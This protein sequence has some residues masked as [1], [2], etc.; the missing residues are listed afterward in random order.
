M[1]DKELQSIHQSLQRSFQAKDYQTAN[2]LL[3]TA[4]IALIQR[5]VLLPTSSTPKAVLPVVRDILE[6]GALVSIY[7]NEEAAFS[8][9]YS[10]L[11]PFYD[12]ATI[13]QSPNKSKLIGLYLLLLLSKNDIAEFHTALETLVERTEDDVFIQYPVMLERW[14]M[15]GSYDKVWNATKSTQVPSEEYSLFTRVGHYCE[16]HYRTREGGE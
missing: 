10:Q 5:N 16:F 9:F 13:P 12:D 11:Q 3:T 8:R 14:L 4:K 7:L 2:Q 1:A 15:E 6:L